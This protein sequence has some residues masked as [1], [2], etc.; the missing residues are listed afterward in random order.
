MAEMPTAASGRRV[1]P[2]RE[3]ALVASL[4]PLLE[5]AAPVVR[6][7]AIWALA[8]LDRARF[9]TEKAVRMEPETDPG[10]LAE[11]MTE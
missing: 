9:A 8:R 5:D 11:W 4:L 10:V 1:Q 2:P 6:G 7:A 3:G